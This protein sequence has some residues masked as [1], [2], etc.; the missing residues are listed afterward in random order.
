MSGRGA[1]RLPVDARAGAG[2]RVAVV[3]ALWH[4]RVA[5]GLLDGAVRVLVA[6]GASHHVV[7]VPGA[8]ELPL[9]AQ[10]SAADSDAVVALGAVIRGETPHFEQV[11]RAVTDGLARVAL[12]TGVP[13]GFGVLTC[14]DEEQALARAGLAGSRE[15][16]GGEAAT[17]ALATV[18]ALR[19]VAAAARAEV[20][21]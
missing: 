9:V 2:L 13:V 7:R 21:P 17:A 8:F 20:T 4:D 5:T 18:A 11:C 3:A 10:A 14:D 12:D 6:S 19:Q 15:D 1:P 16:K